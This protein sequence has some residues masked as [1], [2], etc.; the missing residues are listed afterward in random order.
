MSELLHRPTRRP[1][2]NIVED[3]T[4]LQQPYNVEARINDFYDRIRVI[5]VT[6]DDDSSPKFTHTLLEQSRELQKTFEEH[7]KYETKRVTLPHGS[8]IAAYE[9]L[10]TAIHQDAEQLTRRDLLILH[11][12]G[13]GSYTIR[14][15][16]DS[17]DQREELHY[18]QRLEASSLNNDGD[19]PAVQWTYLDFT[20]IREAHIDSAPCHVLMLMDCCHSGA[21]GC[22]PPCSGKEVLA[23][24]STPAET[25]SEGSFTKNLTNI[26]QEAYDSGQILPTNMLYSRLWANFHKRRL[27]GDEHRALEGEPIFVPLQ[28][29][30]HPYIPIIP[31]VS[32]LSHQ[33]SSTTRRT[34]MFWQITDFPMPELTYIVRMKPA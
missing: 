3:I 26:L 7:Y 18:S 30:E 33:S 9:R 23:A 6:W 8:E 34:W 11:Y 2:E 20:R 12:Q 10:A 31:E 5:H 16:F 22:G 28:P 27:Q 24:S 32:R 29:S 17:R 14:R 15:E 21:V 4:K 13:H 1:W 19:E 25:F